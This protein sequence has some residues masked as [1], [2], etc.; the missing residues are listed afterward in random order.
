MR[1]L[2]KY[3]KGIWRGRKGR[4]AWSFAGRLTKGR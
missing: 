1:K 4:R 2:F 3:K